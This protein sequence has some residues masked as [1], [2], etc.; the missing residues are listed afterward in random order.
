[1][2]IAKV[3]AYPIGLGNHDN[4]YYMVRVK[5]IA[6]I[7]IIVDL[8]T[9]AGYVINCKYENQNI[10]HYIDKEKLRIA[11]SKA[12]LEKDIM[13]NSSAEEFKKRN[14]TDEVEHKEQLLM[15][16]LKKPLC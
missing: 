8:S 14:S 12:M 3:K 15:L 2:N 7:K 1:M 9:E 6:K 4:I 5:D 10:E 13:V 11:V 16:L